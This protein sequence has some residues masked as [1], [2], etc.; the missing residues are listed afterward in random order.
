MT[1]LIA[2][3][4]CF[5]QWSLKT[6]C[7]HTQ[8]CFLPEQKERP[9]KLWCRAQQSRLGEVTARYTVWIFLPPDNIFQEELRYRNVAPA[10]LIRP[11]RAIETFRV[12][13]VVV[14]GRR[15]LLLIILPVRVT[16]SSFAALIRS[17]A[18]NAAP[19]LA[20]STPAAGRLKL[21]YS[22]MS[23][24][25]SQHLAGNSFSDIFGEIRLCVNCS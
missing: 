19:L 21:R 8:S 4:P 2:L 6:C 18:D 1:C 16:P 22:D 14:G 3:L 24:E 17:V 15:L 25:L 13:V 7:R 23:A 10:F 12:D 5:A 11:L 9:L 20:R